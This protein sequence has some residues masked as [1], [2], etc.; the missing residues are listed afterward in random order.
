VYQSDS[1][2]V[3]SLTVNTGRS[4]IIFAF[5]ALASAFGGLFAY[6]LTQ[7][8]TGTYFSSWRALFILEGII[9][10]LACPIFFFLFPE[11]P[12][13]ARFLT[14]EEKE[15]MRLRYEQDPHWGIDDIFSWD[16]VIAALTDPKFYA[17]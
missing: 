8:H 12:T 3:A 9:T 1:H 13:T 16:A 10:I 5:S 11:S 7:I 6:G 15:M 17:L 2:G 14:D 4:S